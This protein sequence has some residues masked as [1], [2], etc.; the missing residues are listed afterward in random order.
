MKYLLS[1]TLILIAF[2]IRAQITDTTLVLEQ[3]YD[4]IPK[5]EKT[6]RYSKNRTILRIHFSK[7]STARSKLTTLVVSTNGEHPENTAAHIKGYIP[8]NNPA[9]I[10]FDLKPKLDGLGSSFKMVI[11]EKGEP[12]SPVIEMTDETVPPAIRRTVSYH[13][14][15]DNDLHLPALS[16]E[17][18]SFDSKNH[19]FLYTGKRKLSLVYTFNDELSPR[20]SFPKRSNAETTDTESIHIGVGQPLSLELI[21]VPNPLRYDVNI[22]SGF[23]SV[24]EETD[25]ILEKFLLNPSELLGKAVA[26]S[27]TIYDDDEIKRKEKILGYLQQI[28]TKLGN[29][30][31]S[32]RY[33]DG[34]I[35]SQF[36]TERQAVVDAVHSYLKQK[37]PSYPGTI[38]DYIINEFSAPDSIY[39]KPILKTLREFDNFVVTPLRYQIKQVPD[40][41]ELLLD[42]RISPKKGIATAIYTDTT[43]VSFPI[44][45]GFKVDVSPGLFYS[46][47]QQ[48]KYALRTDSTAIITDGTTTYSRYKTIITEKQSKGNVGFSSLLHFY[49]RW[50]RDV[51]FALSLGVGLTLEDTPQVRYLLG[52]S[53]LIGRVNRIAVS[54]GYSFGKINQLSGKYTDS[55]TA[56]SD[57]SLDTY[58]VLK[59]AAFIALSYNIPLL[60]RKK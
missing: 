14:V 3:T 60:N 29:Y 30:L 10:E 6:G 7:A 56:V 53:L 19:S 26:F 2:S 15:A 12:Y 42:I 36:M 55:K 39:L 22:S 16:R 49:S 52:G 54:G 41:D 44:F 59:G 21:P 48:Q 17:E 4:R 25:G 27:G 51:N 34:I 11:L 46:F 24:N 37:D 57:T 5:L 33:K 1:F 45:G 20:F 8:D 23:R 9:T 28:N 35:A 31:N 47:H 18:P 58:K 32:Y 40:K 43:K 38:G 13:P 50:T